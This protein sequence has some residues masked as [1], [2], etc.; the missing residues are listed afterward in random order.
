MPP[1][2]YLFD[3]LTHTTS[4]TMAKTK[5]KPGLIAENRQARHQYLLGE[6]FEAGLALEGW[7]VKSIRAGRMQLKEGY[8]QL[9]AGEAWLSHA[10]ISPL[11]TTS[12]HIEP[13]PIRRRKCLLHKKELNKLAALVQLKGK[14]IVPLR[15]YWK[16][17][18]IKLAIA[19]GVGKKLHD[20]RHDLKA[21]AI[22][23]AQQIDAKYKD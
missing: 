23:R 6:V 22:A 15:I 7:E 13:D 10:H 19:V 3:I 17:G 20:K 16:R 5:S 21:K 18:L 11:A 12:T 4:C 9:K 1:M 14:T 8:I 2:R